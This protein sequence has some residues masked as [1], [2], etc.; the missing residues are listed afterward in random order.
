VHV[1]DHVA[2]V[3]LDDGVIL[4]GSIIEQLGDCLGC[5]VGGLGDCSG[6]KNN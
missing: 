6:S 2:A 5:I 1:E 3:I 4:G